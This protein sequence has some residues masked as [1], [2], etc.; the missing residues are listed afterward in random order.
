[1]LFQGLAQFNI[2]TGNPG[3]NGKTAIL[4]VESSGIVSEIDKSL[5][6]CAIRLA[7]NFGHGQQW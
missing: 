3:E 6:G 2:V 4:T 7:A 1:L 5:A